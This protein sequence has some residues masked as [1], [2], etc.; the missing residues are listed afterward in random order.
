MEEQTQQT[1]DTT[2][3]TPEPQ[4]IATDVEKP[5][6]APVP[7]WLAV[8]LIVLLSAAAGYLGYRVGKSVKEQNT[9]TPTPTVTATP[10]TTPTEE[11]TE[12][13]TPTITVTATPTATV[14]PTVSTVTKTGK[15]KEFGGSFTL[16]FTFQVPSDV[17]VTQGKV[18]SWDGIIMKKGTK[19]FMVFNMPYELYELLTYTSKTSVPSTF[20]NVSR[21]RAK[22]VFSQ[23]GAYNFAV[24]YA[25][26]T[27]LFTGTGCTDSM[28]SSDKSK[29][30]CVL[31]AVTDGK[32]IGF[33]A[34]CSVDP[35]YI[36]ICDSVMKTIKVVKG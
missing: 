8:A 21:V 16:N 10:T 24:T 17:T 19:S 33:S 36:A 11:I 20:P 26:A 1:V 18:G 25:S 35:A 14:T 12:T 6:K 4:V 28:G 3:Q 22:Y 29:S 32:E 13:P 23:S 2:V 9:S 30:P 15:I 7:A 31:P 5:P 27:S 34:Y